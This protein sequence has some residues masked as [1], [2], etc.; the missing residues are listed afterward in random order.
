MS[1]QTTYRTTGPAFRPSVYSTG[2]EELQPYGPGWAQGTSYGGFTDKIR[3]WFAEEE[4][5]EVDEDVSLWELFK[6]AA[7]GAA[8]GAVSGGYDAYMEEQARIERERAAESRKQMIMLFVGLGIP[9]TF[10]GYQLYKKG[11]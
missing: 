3:G 5:E 4:P 8:T 2:V 10:I 9:L 1:R 7:S 11:K 6:G